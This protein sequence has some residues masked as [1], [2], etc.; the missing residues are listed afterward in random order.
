VDR[1]S[2]EWDRVVVT[3]SA[4]PTA[5]VVEMAYTGVGTHPDSEDWNA[6]EWEPDE[7]DV[8]GW[9]A[10]CLVGPV[11]GVDLAEGTYERWLRVTDSPEVPVLRVGT[12]AVT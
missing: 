12:L 8:G 9:V 11:D 10:R 7:L 3:A 4:D 1:L 2:T 6:G 5:D